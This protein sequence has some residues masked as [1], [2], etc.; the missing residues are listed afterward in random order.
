LAL[1]RRLLAFRK[2]LADVFAQGDYTPVCIKGPDRDEVIAFSRRS[3]REA[4]I[5]VVGRLMGRASDGGRRWPSSHSWRGSVSLRGFSSLRNILTAETVGTAEEL[6]LSDLFN[7]LPLA[8]LQAE[9]AGFAT[10]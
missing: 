9:D 3:G 5:V 1:T 10:Q 4:A 8:V 6:D 7:V 2:R